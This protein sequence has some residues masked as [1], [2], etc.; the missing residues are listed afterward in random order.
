MDFVQFVQDR[1]RIDVVKD[2]EIGGL[3]RLLL[4]SIALCAGPLAP[5]ALCFLWRKV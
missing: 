5:S 4:A 3:P 2:A 1:T